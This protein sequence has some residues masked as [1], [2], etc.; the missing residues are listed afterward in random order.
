VSSLSGL[1][2][3]LVVGSGGTLLCLVVSNTFIIHKIKAQRKKRM[4]QR[5]FK[6][7][8]GQLLQQLVSQR[9]DIAQRMIVTLEELE[10]AT[11]NFDKARELGGGGHG[12]IYRGFYQIYMFWQLRSQR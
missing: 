6:K 1:I 4:R 10:K 5:F 9:A 8:R 2:I 3:G 12:T 7:N 11:N